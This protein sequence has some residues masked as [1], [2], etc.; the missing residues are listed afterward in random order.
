MPIN[1]QKLVLSSP[2]KAGGADGSVED[3]EI[4]VPEEIFSDD[5]DGLFQMDTE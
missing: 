1:L 4:D 3:E 2:T 5:D